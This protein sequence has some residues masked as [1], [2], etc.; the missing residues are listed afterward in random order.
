VSD[1]LSALLV[2]SHPVAPPWDSADK[3]VAAAIL[4]HPG[5]VALTY[6]G[7]AGHRRGV[8]AGRRLP[9]LSRRGKPGTLEQLQALLIGTSLQPAFDVVHA[10]V[11]VGPGFGRLVRAWRLVPPALRPP[12]VHTVPG[13]GSPAAFAVRDERTTVV[14]FSERTATVLRDRGASDVVVIEPGIDLDAWPLLEP[15]APGPVRI[16]FVG[17]DDPEGGLQ[18]AIAG[19]A[20]AASHGTD[21][22]LLLA[23]RTRPP[24][25]AA[26]AAS[27]ARAAAARAG[28]DRVDVHGEGADVQGL[29]RRASVLV[30]PGTRLHG[31]A[32]IPIVVLEA[33]ASGR[34]VV[35]GDLPEFVALGD[36]VERVPAGDADSL[37]AAIRRVADPEPARRAAG[38]RLVEE[39][40][41]ERAM[42]A[43]Y[44]DL[45]RQVAERGAHGVRRRPRMGSAP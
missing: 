25:G 2:T 34:P 20:V 40:Y 18:T 26:T 29:L 3:H 17:H 12:L 31:K 36:A 44:L 32:D 5:D 24:R 9:L 1:G 42:A 6:F 35:L 28:L 7:R 13:V 22:E 43:R 30:L 19:A 39:R 10:I 16:L 41:S 21:V 15:P 4:R 45:Y 8:D 38:R 11:T 27:A 37:A 23:L 33:L 14:A